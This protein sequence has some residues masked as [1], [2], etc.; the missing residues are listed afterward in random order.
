MSKGKKKGQQSQ[1]EAHNEEIPAKEPIT[2]EESVEEARRRIEA[3]VVDLERYDPEDNSQR[4]S[5]EELEA[6]L[7]R[8]YGSSGIARRYYQT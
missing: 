8:R 5:P 6:M 1:Q 4:L 3:V 2:L 7:S